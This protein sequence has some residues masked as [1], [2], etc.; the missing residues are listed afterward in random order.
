MWTAAVTI[1]WSIPMLRGASSTC[2]AVTLWAAVEEIRMWS[3]DVHT[4]FTPSFRSSHVWYLV[5]LPCLCVYA[6]VSPGDLSA[7]FSSERCK[8]K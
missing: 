5:A 8:G 1:A 6:S 3:G 7:A 2:V 4:G